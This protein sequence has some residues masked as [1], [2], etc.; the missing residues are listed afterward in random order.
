MT[1]NP[2]SLLPGRHRGVRDERGI[3]LVIAL[4]AMLLMTALG[5]ALML[6][7]TTETLIGSNYLDSVEGSYVADAGV[8]R[9]MQDVLSIPEWNQILTSP[10]NVRAGIT[11]GFID[12]TLTPTLADGRVIN[13]AEATNMVNCNKVTPCSDGDMDS[14]MGERVWGENNPR[15]RLFAWGPVNDLVPTNTLNSQYYLA[16]WIADDAGETDGDPSTDGAPSTNPDYPDNKGLGVLTLRAEAFGPRGAHR[17]IE[18]TIAR[19]DSSQ[20]ERGYTGQRGQDEQNRR[21]RKN[22]VGQT[23]GVL[24][25]SE[26]SIGSGAFAKQ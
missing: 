6:T 14:N 8:E 19:T 20:L 24:A 3:A 23:G 10:D 18:A 15:F 9:V 5:M 2:H 21:A 4:L 16:V 7:S 12:S 13:L 1:S 17:V 26:M 22:A 11:S 25:R